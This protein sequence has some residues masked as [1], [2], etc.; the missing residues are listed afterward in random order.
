MRKFFISLF[1]IAICSSVLFSQNESKTISQIPKADPFRISPGQSF[2]ASTVH[3]KTSLSIKNDQ[4]D[5]RTL[6]N[7]FQTAIELI[8]QNYVDANSV[9]INDLTKSSINS[10]LHVLDPHSNYFD[11][12]E[13]EELL[14]DQNSEYSGIGA[15]IANFEEKGNF[16]TYVTS[17]FPDSPAFRSNLRFGDKI[18]EVDGEKVSGKSS[19]YVRN[20]VRGAIGTTIRLKIERANNSTPQIISI[21]RNRVPQPSIPDAYL[22]SPGVGYIDFSN[23]FNYTTMDELNVALNELEKQGMKSLILDL[24][25]NPGGILEQ[26]VRV[27]E[28]F[29]PKGKTIVSQRGRYVMD[30]RKWTSRNLNSINVPL[31]VLVN[32]DSA[33]ASEIVTGALQDFDR[34]YI[35]GEKTFGKGLV[36]SIINLP[37]GSGLTLTT[38]KYYTPSGRSI[39][40]DYSNGNRYDYYQHKISFTEKDK[41]NSRQTESGRTVYG[42]DGITPDEI[43]KARILTDVQIQLLDPIFLFSRELINGQV[44]GFE[45]YKINQQQNY[46]L[47]IKRSDYPVTENLLVKFK[48][49]IGKNSVQPKNLINRESEFILRQIRYNLI[50]AAFG[51]VAAKQVLIEN[52][53]QVLKGVENLPRALE[54]AH[55][56]TGKR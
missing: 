27:A 29:L 23:G 34:A 28:K 18:I 4:L 30:N 45:N 55:S 14:S 10:M 5:P 47:R 20:K 2:S 53:E 36:Q 6:T 9:D 48:E 21:K 1:L 40:R 15:T 49:Y 46:G 44:I 13:Y 7:D 35:V 31:V 3:S 24:R 17:T 51:N 16:E 52:D 43:V 54:L 8:K 26:A 38:A 12:A 11:S 42:G 32:G 37:Y 33:S 22:L 41:Q 56:Y 25:N 19:L 39:Q 50:S